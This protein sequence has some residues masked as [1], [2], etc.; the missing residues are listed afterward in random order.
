VWTMAP[1]RVEDRAHTHG[2]A[3][4]KEAAVEAF[5]K[6]WN[7]DR[8]RSYLTPLIRR[9]ALVLLSSCP[10]GCTKA[11]L[12]AHNIS[13]EIVRRL[14]RNGLAVARG[15]PRDQWGKCGS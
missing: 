5:A 12:A 4:T 14:V 8:T 15:H 13:D 1:W 2:Y 9:R 11:V 6:S 3:E 10:D 7:R